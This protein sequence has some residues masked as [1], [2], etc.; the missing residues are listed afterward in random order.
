MNALRSLP[1]ERL[2]SLRLTASAPFRSRAQGEWTA[3]GVG[4]GM[5][6]ED[7][8]P[9]SPGDDLRRVDWRAAARADRVLVKRT[10]AESAM[11]AL[12]LI[13]A[14]LSM[15][16]GDPPPFETAKRIAYALA[17]LSLRRGDGAAVAAVGSSEPVLYARGRAGLARLERYLERL[18]PAPKANFAQWMRG[19]VG[20]SAAGANAFGAIILLSDMLLDA[21]ECGE[22]LKT[23]AG[24]GSAAHLVSRLAEAPEPPAEASITD[25]ETG[26]SRSAAWSADRSRAYDARFQAHL[27]RIE[28]E[29]AQK[30]IRY[31]RLN[32]EAPIETLFYQE[33]RAAGIVAEAA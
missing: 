31:A 29:C 17:F 10:Q 6:F 30:R 20:R 33:L 12:L 23:M 11:T 1:L 5:L 27:S 15:T 8:R 2:K 14:S 7:R 13:D 25:I 32:I 4:A 19:R 9:Y 22:G 18:E 24:R 3:M 21:D 28:A 26:E 16:A